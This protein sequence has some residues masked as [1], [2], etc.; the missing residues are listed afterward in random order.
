[1][2][3]YLPYPDF[4]ATMRAL[5]NRRLGKQRVEAYQLL[6]VLAGI[7]KGWRN[8]PAAIMWRGYEP[9]LLDY[10]LAACRE[11]G[12]R[13]FRNTVD[14]TLQT[15]FAHLLELPIIKPPWL[16]EEA[17]HA[18]HR[19]SL[20]KKEPDWYRQ[21]GWTEPDDLPY[22]WPGSEA[23]VSVAESVSQAAAVDDV[24]PLMPGLADQAPG[25]S[26]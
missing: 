10:A 6:R 23:E 22:V 15:E 18:S 4:E 7:T 17:F 16:G 19:S 5:D 3:T 12:R 14:V 11:W 2:Q 8:H 25:S 21:F 1:M 9:A 20:L 26:K 24:T 13:G